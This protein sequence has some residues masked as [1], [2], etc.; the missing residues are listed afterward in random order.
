MI[1]PFRSDCIALLVTVTI[2]LAAQPGMAAAEDAA[3][4]RADARA[5]LDSLYRQTPSAK[6]LA[7]NA[8]AVLVFP[9]VVKAGF[10]GGAQYGEGVLMRGGK[11]TSYYNTIQG[12]VGFQAGVE[13]FAYALF[14]MTSSAVSYLDKSDGWELG[15]GP[16]I[17]IVDVGGAA[18]LSTTT[19]HKDIYVFFFDPKG[20]MGG[21]SIQGT[22]ITRIRK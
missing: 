1:S 20:L 5:A 2:A 14:F 8:K 3:G 12:S 22:K 15:V 9:N 7:N 16:E 13:K 19:A 18:Q 4:L 10:I 6:V 21:V 11:W 17:V